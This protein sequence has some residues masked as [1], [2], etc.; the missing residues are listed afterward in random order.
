M[1]GI[2]M[3][4]LLLILAV[5]LIVLGPKKLPEIAKS[6][7]KAMGEFKRATND[8]KHTIEQETGLD[9]VRQSLQETQR[10]LR[11]PLDEKEVPVS[12]PGK[13]QAE[14]SG[15]DAAKKDSDK[16]GLPAHGAGEAKPKDDG[17]I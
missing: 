3:P 6:L 11:K 10:D 1:F 7:G 9:E 8:L 5:A 4:E 2:G 16:P 15:I 12:P 17:A 13:E 14:Q